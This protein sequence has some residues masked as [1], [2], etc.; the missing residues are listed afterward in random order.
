MKRVR[1][2][3]LSGPL[4]VNYVDGKEA[5]GSPATYMEVSR[6]DARFE[7]PAEAIVVA[8]LSGVWGRISFLQFGLCRSPRD[9]HSCAFYQYWSCPGSVDT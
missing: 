4:Y 5:Y 6:P 3:K 9:A 7:N 8:P 1:S 2:P